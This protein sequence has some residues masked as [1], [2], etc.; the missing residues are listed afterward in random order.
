MARFVR[1]MNTTRNAV[2]GGRI[3]IAD[4]FRSRTLGLLG[5]T[6]PL[7]GEGLLLIPCRGIHMIGLRF[8]LD[9]VFLDARGVVRAAF[10]DLQPG[11]RLRWNRHAASTLELP[12]GTLRASGTRRG[13]VIAWLPGEGAG[14]GS[15]PER[16]RNDEAKRQDSPPVS[17]SHDV[18]SKR[19]VIG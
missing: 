1:V 11:L 14:Q 6:P 8:P 2:L 17:Q 15:R 19:E 3:R 9:V 5:S 13:D 18:A 4:D 7:P 10:H 16:I 12:A